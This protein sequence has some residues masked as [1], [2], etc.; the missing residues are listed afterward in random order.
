LLSDTDGYFAA[1]TAYRE[2]DLAPIVERFA[3]ASERAVVNGRQ[4][5]AQ[6]REIRASR[7]TPCHITLRA[8]A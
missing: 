7:T 6:L 4:L 3:H 2:G 5:I 8:V 1:L